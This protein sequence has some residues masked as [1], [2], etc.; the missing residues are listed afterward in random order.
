MDVEMVRC[1]YFSPTGTTG[2]IVKAIA[3]GLGCPRVRVLNRTRKAPREEET[4]TFRD[5]AVILAAPVYYGRLPETV[6]RYYSALSAENTPAVLV[7]VYGNRAY[8]DA[9][10]ELSDIAT[11]R[12]F[13][14]VAGAAFIGEHS[15]SSADQPIAAGRPDEEDL[16]KARQFGVAVRKKLDGLASLKAMEP[17]IVPGNVPYKEPEGLSQIKSLR[18]TVS[19]TPETDAS[20][21]TR[22]DLCAETCPTGAI[23][24]DNLAKTDKDECILCFQCVKVCPVGARTMKD[25]SLSPVVRNIYDTCQA[26]K[27]PEYYL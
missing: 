12:G 24:P 11:A 7:V 19:F 25:L 14:P 10:K 21:C 5:E 8:E 2:A 27:E 23:D 9:L 26:R 18:Q 6:A 22:C 13:I 4:R 16:K 15:Y 17:L 3:P 1:V 20:L